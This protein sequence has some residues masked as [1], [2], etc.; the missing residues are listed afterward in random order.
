MPR[1]TLALISGL[2]VVVIILFAVALNSNENKTATVKK[3]V[4]QPTPTTPAHTTLNLSPNPVVVAPGKQGSVEVNI[5]TSDNQVT[6]IQLEIA[7]DPNII[8]N[9]KVSPGPL[10][11]NAVMLMNHNKKTAGRYVYALGIMP[12][13][14]TING[15][16]Q[17]ATITFTAIGKAGQTSQ[18]AL[19][20]TSLATARGISNSVLKQTSGTLVKIST[21]K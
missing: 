13:S 20:P 5:D 8:T 6:A 9:I 17:A 2:I 14:P 15:N 1:K 12:N 3:T 4:T 19:L 11:A 18:L 16:G 7:Y 10:F 21:T